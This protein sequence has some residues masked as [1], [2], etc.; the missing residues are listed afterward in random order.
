MAAVTT[1]QLLLALQQ[2]CYGSSLV[3]HVVTHA[4]DAD[5]LSVRV[6]LKHADTLINVFYNVTA[7]KVAFALVEAGRRIYG[8]DNAKTGWHEHPFHDST[9]HIACAPVQFQDFLA[10][11]EAHYGYP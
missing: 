11:V 5:T 10:Q 9:Q 2:A 3:D 6:H 8:A 1:G 4:L 7:D